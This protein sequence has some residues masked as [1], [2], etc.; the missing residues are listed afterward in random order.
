M[1]AVAILILAAGSS[2]R[3]RGM[4]KLLEPVDGAPMLRRQT[5]MA[6]ATGCPVLVALPPDRPE[7]TAVLAGLEVVQVRVPDAAK[8]MS[9]SLRRGAE[10][11]GR[12][13]QTG[14]M[15][16]PADMPELTAEALTTVIASFEAVP[17]RIVRARSASGQPGHP[18][19]FP[20][21]LWPELSAISG[22]TGGVSVIQAHPERVT[23]VNLPGDMATLD[24]DTPEEW[25][26]W[27][28]R[29]D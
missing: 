5:L 9:A 17:D 29:R 20:R 7:R 11:A 27:R 18:A 1:T 22:D 28:A 25:Q 26:A 12:L 23:F 13:P 8:G 3:M 21:S 15:I 6:L 14:L 24:L 4:D 2:S 16:L 10:Q 19:I